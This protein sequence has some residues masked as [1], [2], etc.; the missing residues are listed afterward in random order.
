MIKAFLFF[1]L[2]FSN[3]NFIQHFPNFSHFGKIKEMKSRGNG[4]VCIKEYFIL[5]KIL[6][7]IFYLLEYF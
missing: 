6:Y 7:N 4:R 2:T 3:K 5:L 1:F